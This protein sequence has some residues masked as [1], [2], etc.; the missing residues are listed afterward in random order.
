MFII[1]LMKIGVQFAFIFQQWSGKDDEWRNRKGDGNDQPSLFVDRK[2][3]MEE[4]ERSQ[5]KIGQN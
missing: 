3:Q 5:Q 1:F 2:Q 4:N